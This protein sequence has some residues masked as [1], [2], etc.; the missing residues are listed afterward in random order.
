MIDRVEATAEGAAVV[1]YK[2]GSTASFDAITR[3][4]DRLDHG[5][6]LQ[7]GI[8]G[9][10]ARQLVNDDPSADV[11]A[12]YWFVSERQKFKQIGYPLSEV[13]DRLGEVVGA[14][15]SGMEDGVFPANPGES[16]GRPGTS[17]T[18]AFDNC[19]YCDFN[20]LC[21]MDRDR[22]WQSKCG[23]EQLSNYANLVQDE[24]S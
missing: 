5:R 11:E 18:A 2:T 7:L 3:G 8:Y 6:K 10:A 9:L 17:P 14:I 24:L 16:G 21:P 20:S 15:L 19:A 1:D 23:D 13:E 22:L 12:M 4:E